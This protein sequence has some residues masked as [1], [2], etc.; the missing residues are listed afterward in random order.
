MSHRRIVEPQRRAPS[1]RRDV[2]LGLR[3][4]HG[5]INR[6]PKRQV[7]QRRWNDVK[8][9]DADR[10]NDVVSRCVPTIAEIQ[11]EASRRSIDP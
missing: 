4:H 11:T 10:Q 1:Y 9:A 3:E 5:Q 2:G 7:R 8:V 6:R